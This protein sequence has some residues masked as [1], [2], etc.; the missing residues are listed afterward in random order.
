[1]IL[2]TLLKK[3]ALA[4][5]IAGGGIMWLNE[6]HQFAYTRSA[7][8]FPPVSNW[9]R[10][11]TIV[12]VPVMLAIW[13]GMALSQW[14]IDRF[15]GRL[16]PSAQSMLA[17]ATLGGATSLA[18]ILM[19]AGKIFQTGIGTEFAFLASICRSIYPNGNLLLNILQG[20][21]PSTQAFRF[22]ILLQDG[23]N[24]A[25]ANLTITILVIIILEGFVRG[26]V[27]FDHKLGRVGAG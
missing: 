24:L 14:F 18:I 8:E 20:I 2:D 10:D 9:L 17:A 21:F 26:K 11:S 15:G 1:M 23:F 25:L 22:H 3:S 16:S 12:L 5:L 6:W 7:I 27:I 13:I 19:E 4:I